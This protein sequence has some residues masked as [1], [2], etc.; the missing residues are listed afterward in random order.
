MAFAH[1]IRALACCLTAMGITS[2]VTANNCSLT[3]QLCMQTGSPLS[4]DDR[5]AS[6]TFL[7]P[8]AQKKHP[9][10]AQLLQL[11]PI[12]SKSRSSAETS[13]DGHSRLSTE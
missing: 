9:L 10:T 4:S 3:P 12:S 7:G 1:D 13:F 6:S 11:K 2:P 5:G 8:H